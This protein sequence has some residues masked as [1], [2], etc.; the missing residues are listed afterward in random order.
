MDAASSPSRSGTALSRTEII[1]AAITFVQKHDLESLSIRK[2][3]AQLGVAPMSL[4]RHVADKSEIVEGIVDAL[5]GRAG[6][7]DTTDWRAWLSEAAHSLHEILRTHPSALEVFASRPVAT[8]AALDRLEAGLSVLGDAGIDPDTALRAYGLVHT[9]TI[10]FSA[11]ELG[12]SSPQLK[13][14]K[15]KRVPQPDTVDSARYPIIGAQTPDLAAFTTDEQFAYGIT[16]ILDG[17]EHSMSGRSDA[18]A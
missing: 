16:Q 14:G 9:Y 17:I 15:A 11:L 4:Y 13:A 5:L 7:P 3:S 8:P 6:V 2:L 18:G 10:G 12:R 1:R